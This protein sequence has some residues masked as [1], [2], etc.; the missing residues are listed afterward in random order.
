MKIK[1]INKMGKRINVTKIVE[2]GKIQLEKQRTRSC[3]LICLYFSLPLSTCL[4]RS[5]SHL[6]QLNQHFRVPRCAT[7][8]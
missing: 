1:T 2:A 5:L 3:T 4:S 6:L 7:P 8:S